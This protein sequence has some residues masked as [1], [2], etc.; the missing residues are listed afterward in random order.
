MVI[1]RFPLLSAVQGACTNA[2]ALAMKYEPLGVVWSLT[3]RTMYHAF[4]TG[5]GSVKR[6]S[7]IG[8]VVTRV[9]GPAFS[10]AR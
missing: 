2:P 6:V 10:A 8:S 5:F 7:L 4:A 1:V 3:V 9:Y